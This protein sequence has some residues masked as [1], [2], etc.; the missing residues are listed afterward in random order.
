MTFAISVA[1]GSA[2]VLVALLALFASEEKRGR[3][4]VL[5]ALRARF[6]RVVEWVSTK[7][8]IFFEPIGTGAFQ[9]TIHFFIHRLLSRL[10]R[11]LTHFESYLARLQMRNKRIARVFQNSGQHTHLH[12]IASHKEE[13]SLSDEEKRQRKQH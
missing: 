1:V 6:D 4:V 11:V 8:A 10:I 9:A 3:R 12:E 5:A 2:T 13:T 7:T